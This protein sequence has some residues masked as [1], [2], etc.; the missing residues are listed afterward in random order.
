MPAGA[1]RAP[2]RRRLSAR[3]WPFPSVLRSPSRTQPQPPPQRQRLSAARDDSDDSARSPSF[4]S[5]GAP[6]ASVEARVLPSGREPSAGAQMTNEGQLAS[7]NCDYAQGY[8]L[9]RPLPPTQVEAL[10]RAHN[11]QHVQPPEQLQPLGQSSPRDSRPDRMTAQG[12]KETRR[13]FDRSLDCWRSFTV[14]LVQVK[15]VPVTAA[16]AGASCGGFRGGGWPLPG[17]SFPAGSCGFAG[18][19]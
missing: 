9:S 7:L 14:V 17:P 6:N 3:Q 4:C 2:R 15:A 13:P 1:S 11:L 5:A 12:A 16:R 8:F 10:I 18:W 19:R